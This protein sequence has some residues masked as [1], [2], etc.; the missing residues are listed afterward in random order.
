[1]DKLQADKTQ[2]QHQN[3]LDGTAHLLGQDLA[4]EASRAGLDNQFQRWIETIKEENNPQ[5]HQIV[6][7]LQALKAHFGAGHPDKDTIAP[8]LARL[9]KAKLQAAMF[10]EGNTQPR[11]EKLGEALLQAAKTVQ[12]GN[13]SADADLSTD[14]AANH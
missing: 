10:A 4:E 2:V 6:V 9:G 13:A 8:L 11:V 3:H 1:M 7:D 12:G 14:S 5:F